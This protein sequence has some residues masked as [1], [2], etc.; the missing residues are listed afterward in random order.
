MQESNTTRSWLS[1]A[2]ENI[3]EFRYFGTTLAD[4]NKSRADKVR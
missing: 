4:Q 2:L 3:S 1:S